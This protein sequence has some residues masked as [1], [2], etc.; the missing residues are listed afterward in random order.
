M[1]VMIPKTSTEVSI[2][3]IVSMGVKSSE[4]MS[5]MIKVASLP[6]DP[7]VS[8]GEESDSDEIEWD[9]SAVGAPRGVDDS[10][11]R[12]DELCLQQLINHSPDSSPSS[13]S[14][15]WPAFLAYPYR[16]RASR[17]HCSPLIWRT[18]ISSAFSS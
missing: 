5:S 1:K 16:G 4:A 6:P 2:A 18:L 15:A 7:S 3:R 9:L 17:P 10:P 13:S 14:S 11:M 12:W 8:G